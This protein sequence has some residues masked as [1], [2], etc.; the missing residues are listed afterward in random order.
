M[1]EKQTQPTIGYRKSVHLNKNKF[2]KYIGNC[3][4]E[5]G[6]TWKEIVFGTFQIQCSSGFAPWSSTVGRRNPL[7]CYLKSEH[8][9]VHQL[10]PS[11]ENIISS[12]AFGV[13]FIQME[14]S[15]SG[16]KWPRPYD[17]DL[18]FP[19]TGTVL[20][21]GCSPAWEC[22]Q[23]ILKVQ[24]VLFQKWDLSASQMW[25][26][27]V[28]PLRPMVLFKFVSLRAEIGELECYIF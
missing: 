26:R 16:K 11:F 4:L 14:V 15:D 1:Q 21:K 2:N 19:C 28:I 13:N 27:G 10:C 22:L 6:V 3:C 5:L 18:N 8:K 9:I 20:T 7:R 23:D 17:R 24:S 25:F 12:R